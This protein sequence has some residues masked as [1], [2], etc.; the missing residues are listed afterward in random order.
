M[1]PEKEAKKIRD[2]YVSKGYEISRIELREYS[3]TLELKQY[4]RKFTIYRNKKGEYRLVIPQ[5]FSADLKFELMKLWEE[6]NGKDLSGCHLFVDG[7]YRD[8]RAAYGVVVV[9]D[10]WVIGEFSGCFEL[11]GGQRNVAGEIKGVIKGLEWCITSRIDEVF[12]HYDYEG[13][14]KWAR[15]LWKAKNSLTQWYTEK[16][17]KI[18][19]SLRITWVKEKAH[20]GSTY[21]EVADKL[22]RGAL[23]AH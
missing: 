10:G 3:L 4:K 6:F 21:N 19:R 16:I 8:N 9:K 20:S 18:E 12:V 22:A 17:Q 13:L 1:F 2:F 11:R 23:D 15:G 14:E 5:N 7:S